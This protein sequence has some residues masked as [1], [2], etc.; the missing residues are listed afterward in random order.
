M[1]LY[2]V[3]DMNHHL[4]FS[5][6]WTDEKHFEW[7]FPC[8]RR[9]RVDAHRLSPEAQTNFMRVM[10]EVGWT[11]DVYDKTECLVLSEFEDRGAPTPDEDKTP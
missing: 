10:M 2:D 3:V 1:T 8:D 4:V 9:G 5:P 7:V 6:R 11:R